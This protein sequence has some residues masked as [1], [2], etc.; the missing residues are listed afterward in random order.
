MLTTDIA[1]QLLL[2]NLALVTVKDLAILLLNRDRA[3]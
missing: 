3:K 1:L 2:L